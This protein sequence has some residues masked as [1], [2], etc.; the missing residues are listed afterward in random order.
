MYN[1]IASA[2]VALAVTKTV[3]FLVDSGQGCRFQQPT[4]AGTPCSILTHVHTHTHTHLS[5]SVHSC[6]QLHVSLRICTCIYMY[7]V[8]LIMIPVEEFL[9]PEASGA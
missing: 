5:Q 2:V 1:C 7:L 6:L 3:A 4:P 9:W 8:V